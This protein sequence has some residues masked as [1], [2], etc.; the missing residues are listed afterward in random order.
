MRI[1]LAGPLFTPYVR[2]ELDRLAAL[3]RADGHEVFVPHE[4]VIG[5]EGVRP[6]DVY[7]LDRGGLLG[8][9]AVLAV[10][11]GTDVDDGTACEIGMFAE[12]M[13][14]DPHRRGIVG[15][16]RDLR[17]LRGPRGTPAFNLFVHGCI[18][19]HGLVTDDEAVALSTLRDWSA[20]GAS[21]PSGG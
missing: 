9:D 2:A 1:Y 18:R 21:G 4:Q 10:L 15:L 17:M 11:D 12:A 13:V 16:V 5:T 8:A 6:D 19:A 7:A 3:M 20:A 14:R